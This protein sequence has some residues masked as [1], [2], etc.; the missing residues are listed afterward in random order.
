MNWR[1]EARCISL[2]LQERLL[3]FGDADYPL[4][5]QA[6]YRWA[7]SYCYECPVQVEC[8][9]VAC[10]EKERTAVWGG[11]T[12]SQRRRHAIPYFRSN[13]YSVESAQVVLATV[14]RVKP[15]TELYIRRMRDAAREQE[16]V[17]IAQPA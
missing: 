4:T 5:T 6:Q 10:Q 11:L 7:R 14:D 9:L 1:S 17:P 8:L 15:P 2:E 12:E 16:L 13:G 3:F